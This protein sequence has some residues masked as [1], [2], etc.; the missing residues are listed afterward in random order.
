MATV[1]EWSWGGIHYALR[2]LQR[3]VE[4]WCYLCRRPVH[5]VSMHQDPLR[6]GTLLVAL[7]CHGDADMAELTMGPCRPEPLGVVDAVRQ[8]LE[9]RLIAFLPE[10]GADMERMF[11]EM[12]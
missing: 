7:C 1:I 12:A 2:E 11:N 9:R 5:S 6:H 4:P 3:V 8:H 10:Q